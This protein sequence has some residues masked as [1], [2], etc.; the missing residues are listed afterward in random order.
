MTSKVLHYYKGDVLDEL[1]GLVDFTVVLNLSCRQ[2]SELPKL[3]I[4]GREDKVFKMSAVGSSIFLHPELNSLPENSVPTDDKM[5]EI[6]VKLDLK[7]G[8]K[9]KFFFNMLNLCE[10]AGEK[11]LVFGDS[12]AEDRE[13]SM[14]RFNSSP[15]SRVFFGS[16][17]A[18]GEGISLVGASCIIILDTHLNPSVT[19]QAI[20]RAFQ[21]G[22]KKKVDAS[23]V[24]WNTG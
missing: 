2:K 20:G 15:H 1:P 12:S 13:C 8:V 3:N 9:A 10:S 16:I 7:E 5:D 17:K 4:S 6:L 21:P 14:E 11:L 19:R 22:Q 18:C 23:I 24:G